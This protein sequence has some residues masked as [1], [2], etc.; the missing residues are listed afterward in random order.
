MVLLDT[1]PMNFFQLFQD[2]GL[3]TKVEK[4]Y[5]IFQEDESAENLF[6]IQS[7]MVQISKE[8]ESGKELTLRICGKGSII[9][10]TDLFTNEHGYST[11]AKT[12]TNTELFTISKDSLEMLLTEQSVL[13][14][15]YLKWIQKENLKS[16]SLLRDLVLHG[17][18]GALFSTLIR[19]ANTFGE[20]IEENK[21]FIHYNLTNTEI[22]N[23]CSTSREMINR[24]LNDLKKQNII[25]FDKDYITILDLAYLKKEICCDNCPASICRID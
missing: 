3:L 21:V 9:G 10:E 8:T 20:E 19:L 5:H 23:L 24:M 12:L 22:A 11:T 4:G 14:M 1:K 7:G 2:H 16:Q 25:T 18:K 17:K 13:M 6:L 15:E